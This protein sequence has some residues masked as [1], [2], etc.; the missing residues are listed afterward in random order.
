MKAQRLMLISDGT[1]Q[2]GYLSGVEQSPAT[3]VL[4]TG[5]V[6]AW[7]CAIRIFPHGATIYQYGLLDLRLYL[8]NGAGSYD[9]LRCVFYTGNAKNK[10]QVRVTANGGTAW[11][12][13]TSNLNCGEWFFVVYHEANVGGT[14]KH[15]VS[16]YDSVYRSTL[17][18]THLVTATAASVNYRWHGTLTGS[19]VGVGGFLDVEISPLMAGY[20]ANWSSSGSYP[21]YYFL[22]TSKIFSYA[23]F[24]ALSFALVTY[25][26]N[27]SVGSEYIDE[28][29]EEMF[30]S[31]STS[32]TDLGTAISDIGDVLNAVT[33]LKGSGTKDLTDVFG[34]IGTKTASLLLSVAGTGGPTLLELKN[35]FLANGTYGLNALK[36]LFDQLIDLFVTRT[37]ATIEDFIQEF[38][39][40]IMAMA[41]T[42]IT[43]D[44]FNKRI[45]QLV[46][47]VLSSIEVT[48]Y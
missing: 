6:Q 45:L 34:E 2:S 32:I 26:P 15:S 11:S 12:S 17:L 23:E 20:D 18:A 30:A 5:K 3:S 7:W 48:T 24:T 27:F 39:D 33:D 46:I 31:L 38:G 10:F 29:G 40:K 16:L 8:I 44:T 42:K 37:G 41:E 4:S 35:N 9:M 19:T 25:S 13:F 21:P 47:D 14:F 22:I 36:N 1:T 43:G 28:S